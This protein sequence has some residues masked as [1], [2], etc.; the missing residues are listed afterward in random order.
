MQR[1]RAKITSRPCI[2]IDEKHV[3]MSDKYNVTLAEIY[4]TKVQ[5]QPKCPPKPVGYFNKFQG[6]ILDMMSSVGIS[7]E[8]IEAYKKRTEKFTTVTVGGV[9]KVGRPSDF[10][11]DDNPFGEEIENESD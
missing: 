11:S 7:S 3:V 10:R 9:L 4:H 5:G 6:A 2:R 1:G 8:C